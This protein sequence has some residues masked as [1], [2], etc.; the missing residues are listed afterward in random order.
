[1]GVAHSVRLAVHCALIT[2]VSATA[3]YAQVCSS[4]A[5]FAGGK[6][7]MTAGGTFS[8][9]GY[10]GLG[11]FAVGTRAVWIGGDLSVRQLDAGDDLS[12]TGSGVAGLKFP[13]YQNGV[14]EL[15]PVVAVSKS[16]LTSGLAIGVVA[17][18]NGAMR[19][20]PSATVESVYSRRTPE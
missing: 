12:V 16:S 20:I 9:G 4:F 2:L 7:R 5:S 10:G 17:A 15:C 6:I 1:M 3:T 13:L 14:V 18:H 19:L 8:D 11:G